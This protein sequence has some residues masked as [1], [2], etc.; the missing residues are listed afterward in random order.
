MDSQSKV[1]LDIQQ[2][3]AGGHLTPS[4][5]QTL[6]ANLQGSG[7]PKTLGVQIPLMESFI[8]LIFNLVIDVTGSMSGY[9]TV[10]VNAVNAMLDDIEKMMGKTGQE[11]YVRITVFSILNGMENIRVIRD[12][13]HVQDCQR[14]TSVDY[15]PNGLTPLFEGI[16]DGVIATSTFGAS[17]FSYGATG[18]QEV[19]VILSDGH[20]YHP[21]IAP[22]RTN[23]EV[24]R[25]LKELNSKPHFTVAFVGVGDEADFR[26]VALDAGIPEGNIV[27]VE[28]SM[29]GI[30]H[31]LMLV[32]SSMGAKS[33]GMQSQKTAVNTNF[34]TNI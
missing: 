15:V 18:V 29:K 11:I 10:V 21:N 5:S 1:A 9:E 4:S 30:T 20:E 14:L 26:Q 24:R 7:I 27:T 3:L 31:A 34:F 8:P 25:L 16:Y 33:K 22:V 17:A 2:A 6:L 12:F 32:S 28:K 23:D 19:T 13:I